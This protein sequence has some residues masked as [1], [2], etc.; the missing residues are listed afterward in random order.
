[1]GDLIY[2][3]DYKRLEE[4]EYEECINNIFKVLKELPENKRFL[5]SYKYCLE[6]VL[7]RLEYRQFSDL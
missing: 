5:K 3:G 7:N 1:M 4:K 6:E 2:A